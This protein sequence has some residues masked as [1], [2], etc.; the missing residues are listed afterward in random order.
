M[1]TAGDEFAI[2]TQSEVVGARAGSL[3]MRPVEVVAAILLVL[4]VGLLLAG[5]FT[6]YVL[7]MP[8]VWIDEAASIS[9]LWFAMLGSAIAIDRNEH[10]RLTVF[11]N[12]FPARWRGLIETLATLLAITALAAL[13]MPAV[14]Y[15]REESWVT[16]A[17]LKIPVSYRVSAIVVGIVL[18]LVVALAH[19]WRTAARQE[20]VVSVVIIAALVGLGFLMSPVLMG[21]GY[22]NIL[23][24]LVGVAAFC[25]VLGVPIAFCFAVGTIGFLAFTTHVPMIV[26]I[27]RMD[28]GMS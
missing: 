26:M 3:L 24:F 4:I 25:L 21:L 22:F 19:V 10:L 27:G 20:I 7:H 9:F 6:R 5:V 2:E 16:S 14:D 8:V 23:I 15:V 18:M 17:A 1:A 28:E 11:I 12:M 13:L